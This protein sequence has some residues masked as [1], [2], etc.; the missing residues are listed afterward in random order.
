MIL[1]IL[2]FLMDQFT[3][4]DWDAVPS[5]FACLFVPERF[6]LLLDPHLPLSTPNISPVRRKDI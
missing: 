2:P 6:L 5:G 3:R 4:D 1:M